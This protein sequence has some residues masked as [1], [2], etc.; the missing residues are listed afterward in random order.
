MIQRNKSNIVYAIFFCYLV[1]I[2]GAQFVVSTNDAIDVHLSQT[3]E[4]PS[5][6]HW[7]G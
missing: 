1:I 7:L 3:F 6:Q 4:A 2:I 5:L